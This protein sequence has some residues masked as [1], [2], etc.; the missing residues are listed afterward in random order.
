P[1]FPSQTTFGSWQTAAKIAS[2]KTK[3]STTGRERN[4]AT[5]PSLN[6]PAM[7]SRQPQISTSPEARTRY[8]SG[9]GVPRLATP[10]ASSTAEADVPA[11]TTCLLVPKTAYA[12]RLTSSVY[13]PACGARPVG[14]WSFG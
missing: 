14:A 12:A 1:P 2:P 9:E 7:R 8:R 11:A 10:D 3:P 4:C 13:S 5:K 6:A